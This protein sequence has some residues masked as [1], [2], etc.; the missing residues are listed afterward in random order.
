[1]GPNNQTEEFSFAYVR[2]AASTAGCTIA[3]RDEDEGPDQ[4]T[5]TARIPTGNQF[6][7]DPRARPDGGREVL[8]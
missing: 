7:V 5:A 4:E 6:T 3:L 1:M 8:T 2:A